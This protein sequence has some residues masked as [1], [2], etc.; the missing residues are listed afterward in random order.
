MYNRDG[1]FVMKNKKP[2][3]DD[4][5]L[6]KKKNALRGRIINRF[7]NVEDLSEYDLQIA[8]S[9]LNEHPLGADGLYSYAFSAHYEQ[10]KP[11]MKVINSLMHDKGLTNIASNYLMKNL[12]HEISGSM[13][14]AQEFSQLMYLLNDSLSSLVALKAQAD[15]EGVNSPVDIPSLFA[16]LRGWVQLKGNVINQAYNNHLAEKSLDLE[17]KKAEGLEKYSL[18]ELQNLLRQTN[19]ETT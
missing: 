5:D 3:K 15:E 17:E 18:E 8:I 16:E 12:T 14:A 11:Y 4:L 13:N 1:V 9:E 19:E 2:K 7:L 10:A 6:I